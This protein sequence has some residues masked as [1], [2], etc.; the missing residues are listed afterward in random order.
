MR[1]Y[2]LAV[3]AGL[4][5]A[6]VAA[7]SPDSLRP[8][9]FVTVIPGAHYRAG[10]LHRALFG[11][12][13]RD[14][15][16][17]PIRVE[18]LDLAT[19]A[20]GLTP[21]RRG[22]GKQTSTLRLESPDGRKW[23]FRS[24]D[25]DPSPLLPPELRE[26]LAERILQDQISASHPAGALVVPPLLEAVGVRSAPP[27]LFVMPDD[28]ALGEFRRDFAGTLGTLEE[29]PSELSD[30]RPGF[31]SAR[32][33]IDTDELFD[34]LDKSPSERIDTLM[35]LKARLMDLFLGD[36]DRHGGQ[37]RWIK[38]GEGKRAPWQPVP[39]DRDQAFVRYD[40]L[41]LGLA[42]TG[43]PQL[44]NFG[45]DYPSTFGI[46]W[47]ARYID[48][49]LLVGLERPV[50]DSTARDLAARLTDSVID[51]AVHRLPPELYAK[52]GPR[53]TRALE[54]RRDRLPEAAERLY[55]LLAGVV[56]VH[57]TDKG[58][59]ATAARTAD[60]VLDLRIRRK[61]E[62]GD[63]PD[64]FFHRR[65]FSAE[66]KE[67]RLFLGGGKDTV[68]VSG[69]G[70][71]PTLRVIGAETRDGGPAKFVAD[72]AAGGVTR[73]Y[74]TSPETRVAGSHRPSLDRRPYSP[75]DS[76][77]RL[78]RAPRDWGRLWS[79]W[80]WIDYGS[81][82][83]LFGGVSASL[84]SFGF[85]QN[86]YASRVTLR[87]GYA[88]GV[89]ALRAEVL[90]D[91]RIRNSTTRLLLEARASGVDVVR[92]F[93]FGNETPFTAADDFYKVYQQQYS[94]SVG[95]AHALAP[96]LTFRLGPTVKYVSTD[97]DRVTLVAQ[98]RPYGSSAFGMV[99]GQAG[100]DLDTRNA[101]TGATSGV[102]LLAGGSVYPHAWDVQSTFGEAHGEVSTYLTARI[103]AQPTLALRAGGSK[104]W[105]SYPFFEAAFVGGSS[106][107]RGLREHRYVG[108]AAA[109]GN[110]E[111][112][113]DLG[114]YYVV[115][116][117]RWGLL[118]VADA[119]RVW[120]AGESSDTWH[121]GFGGGLW[122]APLARNNTVSAV[123]V[124][125]EGRTGFYFRGG[126]MF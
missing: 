97:L 121:H 37:W 76:T 18:V 113:L 19:Y 31:D 48:R 59:V 70:G 82:I 9:A 118:G 124:R 123:V 65:F 75:P 39:Y 46:A 98:S 78:P 122:F 88:T 14:L 30:D 95:V 52:D 54:R 63:P 102:R 34:R 62:S 23:A 103:P 56:D 1:A 60:G 84:Y 92:F 100:V 112:R 91:F 3:V 24:V 7:Q 13:Y 107:V 126:F 35:F 27:R 33:V 119:G 66:T 21:T 11:A 6:P 47:N 89:S 57:A 81:D 28:P 96:N 49:R 17:T 68:L 117:G 74:D 8:G 53:L 20:G 114:R 115:L 32:K 120:L 40:G 86:P 109:W 104:V 94:L 111:L 12:H 15:W 108:D 45:D 80:P 73:V 71:G 87:A 44:V 42:R 4:A 43:Y 5:G 79:I 41:L 85:R 72:D 2:H 55:R 105:G 38:V 90:G 125:S 16:T 61:D 10:G 83:G 50:W 101:R 58:E 69:A 106:T 29:R 64:D 26:S 67:V 51:D 77:S 25:K 22:G 116:P 99:G 36:W 93:G 110:A